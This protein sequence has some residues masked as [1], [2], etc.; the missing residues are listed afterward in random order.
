MPQSWSTEFLYSAKYLKLFFQGLENLSLF[1]GS[2]LFTV[3]FFSVGLE[4]V[5]VLLQKV[6]G[7]FYELII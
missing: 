6:R 2:N 5:K 4:F 7:G 3:I 1:K